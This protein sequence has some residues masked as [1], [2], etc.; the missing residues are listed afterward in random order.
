[1]HGVCAVAIQ[2]GI[3]L[4]SVVSL[5]SRVPEDH[6]LRKVR[7][8]LDESPESLDRTFEPIYAESGRPSIRRSRLSQYLCAPIEECFGWG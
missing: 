7:P 3:T 5:V 8:L 4:F 6:P 1:M 2:Q